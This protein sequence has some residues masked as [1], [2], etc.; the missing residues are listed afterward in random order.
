M[1]KLKLFI[2]A[3]I[4]ALTVIGTPIK[5]Y[6]VCPTGDP[7]PCILQA[8]GQTV[9]DAANW[10]ENIFNGVKQTILSYVEDAQAWLAKHLSTGT[11][12]TQKPG[13]ADAIPEIKTVDLSPLGKRKS[14]SLKVQTRNKEGNQVTTNAGNTTAKLEDQVE[15]KKKEQMTTRGDLKGMKEQRDIKLYVA[16]QDAIDALAKALVIKEMLKPL[17]EINQEIDVLQASLV[18]YATPTG[19]TVNNPAEPLPQEDGG[20]NRVEALKK[21]LRLRLIWDALL[22]TQQQLSAMRLKTASLHALDQ[23]G[24]VSEDGQLEEIKTEDHQLKGPTHDP[25]A[26][27]PEQ[28]K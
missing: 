6:A 10:I 19:A 17:S 27:I 16:Q 5:V 22:T 7:I 23:L 18:P 11:A 26:K 14:Y 24:P 3:I 8:G 21:N 4:I 25:E 20:A 15:A 2:T 28:G 9:Q 1:K 13:G 12:S